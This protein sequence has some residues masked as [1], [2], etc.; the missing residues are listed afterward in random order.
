MLSPALP[1]T[2]DGV[3]TETDGAAA[4]AAETKVAV[5]DLAALIV[6]AHWFVAPE[7]SPDQLVDHA[8]LEEFGGGVADSVTALLMAGVKLQ[9]K[10]DAQL[11]TPFAPGALLVT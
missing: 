8:A 4:T 7:Q 2:S 3:V 11:A 5:T 10:P 6:S 9:E 1:T